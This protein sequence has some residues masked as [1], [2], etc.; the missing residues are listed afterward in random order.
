M[1]RG[2]MNNMNER[3]FR[4]LRPTTIHEAC[5]LKKK[6]GQGAVFWAGGTDLAPQ[7]K[8]ESLHLNHC[9]DLTFIPD[10]VFIKL[11]G[12]EIQMGAL[13]KVNDI[14]ESSDIRRWIPSLGEA[15]NR[16]GSPEI[17]NMA[18]IGGNLCHG[19]P[20]ADLPIPLLALGARLKLSRA[21]GERW[22]PVEEFFRGVN[23]VA[24]EED[25]LLAEI[26]VSIPP[27]Y[28]QA[29]FL[30]ETRTSVDLAQV[31]AAVRITMSD[32]KELSDVRI[33]L[34]AVAPKPIRVHSAES[35]IRGLTFHEIDDA[36]V[37][38]VSRKAA[39]ETSPIT[40]LRASADY[41]R[42][43][44]EVLVRRGLKQLIQRLGDSI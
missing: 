10:L 5:D 15:A 9:I 16:L 40:D 7:W 33:A 37:G 21:T 36:L 6:L 14:A 26:R 39:A 41:R 34:G 35:L 42:K 18:T 31:N 4:Y 17:R 38:M 11:T 43:L 1:A 30:K 22:V 28:T 23:K 29:V 24:L 25:E 12:E 8:D 13:T 27:S 44:S 20:A 2:A 19:S 32:V 3:S